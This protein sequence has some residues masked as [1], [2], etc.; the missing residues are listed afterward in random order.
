M[1][2]YL[3]GAILLYPQLARNQVV[4]TAVN[5]APGVRLPVPVHHVTN[6]VLLQRLVN[7]NVMNDEATLRAIGQ[8]S[9]IEM[10]K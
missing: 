10:S 9:L 8:Y 5:V 2:D 1:V 4:H 3:H 6:L 7:E